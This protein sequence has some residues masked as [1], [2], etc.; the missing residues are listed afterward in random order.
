M[1]LTRLSLRRPV[2][3]AMALTTVVI[4][5]AVSVMK[6]PL[7]FLPRVEMPFIG[8]QVPVNN[9]IPS[10]V[11][12]E[13]TAPIEEPAASARLLFPPVEP[14]VRPRPKV[15]APDVD[16]VAAQYPGQVQRAVQR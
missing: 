1:W 15:E 14:P 4:L 16:R 5:G 10:Q 6:L 3:L 13:I 7:D 8:V 12:R 11:E 2:T 9:G